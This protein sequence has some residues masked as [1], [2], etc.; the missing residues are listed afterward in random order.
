VALIDFA[1]PHGHRGD[2][3]STSDLPLGTVIAFVSAIPGRQ[4]GCRLLPV[5]VRAGHS[6]LALHG[7]NT[8]VLF[9][10]L[11]SVVQKSHSIS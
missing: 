9:P 11:A 1:I 5:F 10:P 3:R 2:S 6:T 4:F 8:K 7:H